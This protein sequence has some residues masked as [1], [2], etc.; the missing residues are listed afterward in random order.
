MTPRQT[1]LV[2]ATVGLCASGCGTADIVFP[3]NGKTSGISLAG[4]SAGGTE[5]SIAAVR[6]GSVVGDRSGAALGSGVVASVTP[7]VEALLLLGS[8]G[9][10]GAVA[11]GS[12]PP[13]GSQL[14]A[15]E[16]A[17][18]VAGEALSGL[19]C[20]MTTF[21]GALDHSLLAL[22][23]CTGGGESAPGAVHVFPIEHFA[24]SRSIN[25]SAATRI[26]GLEAGGRFG[27]SMASG[28]L[29]GDGV[30]DLLIGAPEASDGGGQVYLLSADGALDIRDA[31]ETLLGPS[32]GAAAALGTTL[33]VPGDVTGDGHDDAI[34]CAPGA[35]VGPAEEAGICTI[36]AGGLSLLR[37]GGQLSESRYSQI[38]GTDAGDLLGAGSRAIV[39][40]D[41]DG[42]GRLDVAVGAP[43][44]SLREG[45]AGTVAIW[46][47]DELEGNHT[48]RDAGVLAAGDGGA[49]AA[50]AV[51]P[52]ADGD[53]ADELLVGSPD[54]DGRRGA[55]SLVTGIGPGVM[56]LPEDA[57][58]TWTGRSADQRL[59]ATLSFSARLGED[60]LGRVLA[61]APGDDAGGEDAGRVWIFSLYE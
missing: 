37:A 41:F 2:V 48:L 28:D 21:R 36:H 60:G 42:N 39:A 27:A 55:V 57:R 52:D 5:A 33:V 54:H 23:A 47:D 22:G 30:D 4:D 40:G 31:D 56:L 51:V 45:A 43:G 58:M 32:E 25:T 7:G 53:N 20:S 61:G 50:L 13:L 11:A 14:P 34:A 38:R 26:D 1:M 9:G 44:R 49:G 35:S 6:S 59:G 12:I 16:L 19:G 17:M 10:D 18:G 15:G 29:D 24:N 3:G 8:P 46:F